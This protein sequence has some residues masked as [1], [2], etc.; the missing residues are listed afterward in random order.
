MLFQ[1]APS[2]TEGMT[3]ESDIRSGRIRVL[4]VDDHPVMRDGIAY[5]LKGQEDIELVAEAGSGE[6]AIALFKQ[7][8]P[9]ITLMDLGLPGMDGIQAVEEIRR[10]SCAAHIIV[11]TSHM[12][13]AMVRRALRA[14]VSGYLL[15]HMLRT[16]LIGTIRKVARGEKAISPAIAISLAS[17][18]GEEELSA[19]EIEVLGLVSF[20][21]SNKRVASRLKVSEDTVKTHMKH[22]LQKLRVNDRTHA[23]TVAMQ[24]GFLTRVD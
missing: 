1:S 3:A 14:G 7:S 22:I 16:D 19:R 6:E 5:A 24:R 18:M 17:R 15:K 11:L 12:G 8:E 2:A 4:C 9:D 10:V 13:D 21:N 23:V 20:G